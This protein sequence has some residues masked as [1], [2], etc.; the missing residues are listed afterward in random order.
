MKEHEAHQ[1]L[2]ELAHDRVFRAKAELDSSHARP[3]GSGYCIAV[4]WQGRKATVNSRDEWLSIKEAWSPP[5]TG[6][7]APGVSGSTFH[8]LT[9]VRAWRPTRIREKWGHVLAE[10]LSSALT[11]SFTFS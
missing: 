9:I 6:P 8:L 2:E 11:P 7:G 3:D 10:V 1:P 4:T 5:K